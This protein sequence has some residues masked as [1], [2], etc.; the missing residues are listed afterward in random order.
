MSLKIQA[1]LPSAPRGRLDGISSSVADSV[2]S[3]WNPAIRAA[4][5]GKADNTINILEPIG[6]DPWTGGGVTA[7]RISAALKSIGSKNDVNL[8]INSPGGDMFE[9]LAIYNLLREHEGEVNVRVVGLAASA[10][11]V[12]AMGGD[13]VQIARAG[14]F[15]VHNAWVVAAGNRNDLREYADMLEPFDNAMASIYSAR[16]G[17]KQDDM[18]KLM[19]KETWIGGQ[20]AVDQG[21][22]DDLLDSDQVSEGDDSS[23]NA[24]SALYKLDAALARAGVPRSERKE[25]LREYAKGMPSAAGGENDMP[26]AVEES[27]FSGLALDFSFLTAKG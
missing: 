2:M 22:A 4:D 21:F 18:A 15:M 19:D 7:R 13:K 12:I 8:T 9:G 27:I 11:S 14:F 24:R 16:T 6:Y 5:D 3:R 26:G 1:R 23:K 20:Q 25:L 10:G 17:S